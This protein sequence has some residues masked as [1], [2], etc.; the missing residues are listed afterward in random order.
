VKRIDEKPSMLFSVEEIVKV[1]GKVVYGRGKV[2][3]TVEGLCKDV[4]GLSFLQWTGG[5][6]EGDTSIGGALGGWH[7]LYMLC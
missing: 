2:N 4:V 3:V 6:L 7:V 1:D 5:E